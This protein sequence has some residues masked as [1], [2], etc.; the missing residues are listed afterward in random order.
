MVGITYRELV[1][2]SQKNGTV[3]M[4]N[5]A[6]GD[7]IF[8]PDL[9]FVGLAEFK[10]RAICEKA[11]VKNVIGMAKVTINVSCQSELSA[12]CISPTPLILKDGPCVSAGTN[13]I[14]I[15]V[16]DAGTIKVYNQDSVRVAIKV[17]SNLGVHEIQLPTTKQSDA[18][19]AT[20]TKNG[21]S[22]SK[23][24]NIITFCEEG[25]YETIT[26]TYVCKK[27]SCCKSANCCKKIKKC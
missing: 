27:S 25:D 5:G 13:T 24:S 16:N 7:F 8:K 19:Y 20:F 6:S 23:I 18:F 22:E 9:G 15:S 4:F 1:S 10:Y 21:K 2:G 11:G 12:G 17:V 26:E 3:E 14:N